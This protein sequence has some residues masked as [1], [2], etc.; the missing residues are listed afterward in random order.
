M[1]NNFRLKLQFSEVY[2]VAFQSPGLVVCWIYKSQVMWTGV[3]Y[4]PFS[5]KEQMLC[6]QT[7]MSQA[8]PMLFMTS[9]NEIKCN[10][11]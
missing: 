9:Y 5:E 11:E 1:L 6:A 2:S 8:F 3:D 7:V 10:N 4:F